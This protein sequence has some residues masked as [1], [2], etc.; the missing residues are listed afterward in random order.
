MLFRL[1]Y[2]STNLLFQ[3]NAPDRNALDKLILASALNNKARS[4]TGILLY[5]ERW[6]LQ[7][8]EGERENIS[9]SFLTIAKDARHT[10]VT[11]VEVA[12][13]NERLFPD[14]SMRAGYVPGN[15]VLYHHHGFGEIFDPSVLVGSQAVLLG[16]DL[17]SRS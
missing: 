15:S 13:Q 7:V 3:E 2:Y 12:E 6:F 14:W 5:D 1:I 10:G 11:L 8:L 4:I 17:V 9:E 16:L